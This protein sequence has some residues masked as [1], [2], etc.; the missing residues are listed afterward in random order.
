MVLLND[1]DH[2]MVHQ[3][4]AISIQGPGR[5]RTGFGGDVF[6]ILRMAAVS[7]VLL[8]TASCGVR[9]EYPGLAGTMA[10]R[11]GEF[12]LYSPAQGETA[13]DVARLFYGSAGQAW[14]IE[15]AGQDLGRTGNEALIVPLRERRMGG[16]YPDGYQGVPIL[17]YH[18]FGTG[19]GSTMVMPPGD[20][21]RQMGYLKN[22]GYRVISPAELQGFL[23]FRH[24]IP[25]KAVIISV[26]DGYRSFLEEAYPIMKKYGFTATLFVYTDY[27]GVSS[28]ALSWDDLRFLKAQGFTIGSHSVAHSDLT[29]LKEGESPE[30]L[31]RRLWRDIKVSKEI[32]D[33]ELGQDTACFSFPFGRSNP[34]VVGMVREAG[35][36]LA[37]SVDRGSNPFFA[38][39]LDLCRDMILK[40]DLKTFISR[41]K[42]FNP[43]V[44]R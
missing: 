1:V 19:S 12:A 27:I 28:K 2:C 17:C 39:P 9:Q 16:L 36:R 37:F 6:S 35:Y 38:D 31:T 30:D 34:G 3:T 44:L 14:R 41:L 13:E 18:Q 10:G 43:V 5:T 8:V 33:R 29:R 26:D 15:D 22:H 24:Q 4:V 11:S 40:R 42:T 25:R 7:V 20:F 32:I 23:E 21:D